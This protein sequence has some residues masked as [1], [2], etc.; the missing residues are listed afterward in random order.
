MKEI[1]VTSKFR[2]LTEQ[3]Y[4]D[5][6]I[7]IYDGIYNMALVTGESVIAIWV[8]GEQEWVFVSEFPRS[9]SHAVMQLYNSIKQGRTPSITQLISEEQPCFVAKMTDINCAGAI[10]F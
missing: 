10:P 7:T 9:E 2:I 1:S 6:V 5:D 4:P 8:F 3:L